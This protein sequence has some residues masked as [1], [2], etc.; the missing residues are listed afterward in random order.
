M[1]VHICACVRVCTCLCMCM[2][3]CVYMCVYAYVYLCVCTCVCM[4]VQVYM[5]CAC[6]GM[7]LCSLGVHVRVFVC[8]YAH[9]LVLR[10]RICACV[11]AHVFA[12]MYVCRGVCVCVCPYARCAY[13]GDRLMPPSAALIT[14]ITPTPIPAP[15]VLSTDPLLEFL[16]G[17]FPSPLSHQVPH[18]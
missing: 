13:T 15:R 16:F 11:C 2:C 18:H 6:A 4:C 14:P 17:L 8:R 3:M 9:F 7:L 12:C 1:R 5:H 10:A